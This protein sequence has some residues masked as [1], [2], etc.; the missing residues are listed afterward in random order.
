MSI[1]MFDKILLYCLLQNGIFW[2]RLPWKWTHKP[3][4]EMSVFGR[5][6]LID[7]LPFYLPQ[8]NFSLIWRRHHCRWR[9]AKCRPMLVTQ[10]LWVGRDLY[11]ATPAVTRDLGFSGLIRRTAPFWSPLATYEGM[12][13]IYSNPDPHRF[14]VEKIKCYLVLRIFIY[15]DVSHIL[16]DKVLNYFASIKD[17]CFRTF[18]T[19]PME[20]KSQPIILKVIFK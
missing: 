9:A 7:Y 11:R 16:F 15:S 12:W 3:V 20:T 18:M 13:R 17:G 1:L 19:V 4:K 5:D 14:F 8:K 6:R 2:W 10:G